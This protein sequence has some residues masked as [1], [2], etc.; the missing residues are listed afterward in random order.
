MNIDIYRKFIF[1]LSLFGIA[2]SILAGFYDV[3]FGSL[4][5]FIHLIL[6][7]IEQFLDDLVAHIFRTGLQAR[8]MIVFYIMLAIGG[9]LI[10]LVWKML[11]EMSRSVSQNL[12]NEWT[13]LSSAIVSDWKSMSMTNRVI[14]VS[15]FLL[16]NYLATFLLF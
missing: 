10:Y 15:V 11:V 16:V 1:Y 4:W 5:E 2:I 6:E 12:K 8:Q 7:F 3:I 13:E 14:W 9:A